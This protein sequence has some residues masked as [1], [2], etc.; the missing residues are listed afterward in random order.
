MSGDQADR[1]LRSNRF[2]A[3]QHFRADVVESILDPEWIRPCDSGA[4]KVSGASITV[5]SFDSDV[6]LLRNW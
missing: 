5:I 6:L 3:S 4:M 2:I 1:P